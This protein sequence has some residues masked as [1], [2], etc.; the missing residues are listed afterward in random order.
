MYKLAIDND[1]IVDD[2]AKLVT[3]FKVGKRDAG[4]VYRRLG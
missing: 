1:Y 2:Q 4:E 3:V